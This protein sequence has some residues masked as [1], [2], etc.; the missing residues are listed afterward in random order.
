MLKLASNKIDT[1]FL[2]RILWNFAR[3]ISMVFEEI[4]HLRSRAPEIYF[5]R[6]LKQIKHKF[7][8]KRQENV[9]IFQALR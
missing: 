5:T 6:L 8:E 9:Q 3:D 4:K 1:F 7:L 2:F